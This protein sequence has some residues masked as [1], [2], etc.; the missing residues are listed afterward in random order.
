MTSLRFPDNTLHGIEFTE[1][2]MRVIAAIREGCETQTE[3]AK[4]LKLRPITVRVCTGTIRRKLGLKS[5]TSLHTWVHTEAS[6]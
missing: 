3:I 1:A 2:E 5:F 4:R 6:E